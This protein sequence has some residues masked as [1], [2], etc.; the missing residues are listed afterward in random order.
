MYGQTH[1]LEAL[2]KRLLLTWSMALSESVADP[3]GA[4]KI[5]GIKAAQPATAL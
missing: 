1:V 2:C 5:T 4:P 3:V